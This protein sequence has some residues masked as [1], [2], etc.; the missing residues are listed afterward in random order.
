MNATVRS[1]MARSLRQALLLIANNREV[2]EI[3]RVA[4]EDVLVSMRDAHM[5]IIGRNN[6]LVIN[7]YNGETSHVIR[8]GPEDALRIGL[9]AMAKDLEKFIEPDVLG[10]I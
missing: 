4:I 8:M 10:N 9:K 5:S 1:D 3:G 6:G 2:L 7:G